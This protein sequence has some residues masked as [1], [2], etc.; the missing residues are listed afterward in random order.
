[1]YASESQRFAVLLTKGTFQ[2]IRL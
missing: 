1:M 2:M